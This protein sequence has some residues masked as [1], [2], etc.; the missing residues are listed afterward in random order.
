MLSVRLE[1]SNKVVPVNNYTAYLQSLHPGEAGV[2]ALA[3]QMNGIAACLILC[4]CLYVLICT[5]VPGTDC[6][7]LCNGF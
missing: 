7:S 5:N 6:D 3:K 2:I 1:D 4:S